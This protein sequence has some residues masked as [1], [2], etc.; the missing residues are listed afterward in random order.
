MQVISLDDF[1]VALYV[2]P[3]Y[4]DND[5]H[6]DH[7]YL[8]I[9]GIPWNSTLICLLISYVVCGRWLICIC[10]RDLICITKTFSTWG[11]SQ[12]CASPA[13]LKSKS[14]PSPHGFASS[15]VKS[16]SAL[17]KKLTKS[18][19]VQVHFLKNLI[20][21]SPSPMGKRHFKSSPSQVHLHQSQVF[22]RHDYT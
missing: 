3:N 12:W 15:Q 2:C 14:S 17:L 21:S 6:S 10:R 1:R 13:N 16:K 9:Q 4:R 19:Q 7:S 8:D 22:P 20:K 5:I 11:C 18:S